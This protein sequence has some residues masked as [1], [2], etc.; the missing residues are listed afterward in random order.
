MEDEVK[1]A[2]LPATTA[3]MLLSTE[4]PAALD[5]LDDLDAT[6]AST[7]STL[8]WTAVSDR[9]TT[10]VT[11][12]ITAAALSV[13]CAESVF[14]ELVTAVIVESSEAPAALER[15]AVLE[16]TLARTASAL[17][18]TAVEM[19][20]GEAETTASTRDAVLETALVAF[21]DVVMLLRRPVCLA[22]SSEEER[23]ASCAVTAADAIVALIGA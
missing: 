3:V 22:S 13:L 7:F 2:L 20:T 8:P 5:R 12:S 21:P 17:D 10:E 9:F 18:C 1:A 23:F 4:L 15:L 16:V 19:F 6:L 14:D 11:D